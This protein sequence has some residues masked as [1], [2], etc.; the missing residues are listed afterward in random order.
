PTFVCCEPQIALPLPSTPVGRKPPSNQPHVR[1][2]ALS[3]SPT[4]WPDIVTVPL[5]QSSSAVD[6]SGSPITVP[7]S[8]PLAATVAPC[9]WPLTRSSAPTVEGPKFVPNELSLS[10]KCWA[11]FQRPVTV[12]P[13]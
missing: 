8:T 5:A 7:F 3:R 9:V 11:R 2:L 1:C 12:L 10:A 6:G 4:F 13:S